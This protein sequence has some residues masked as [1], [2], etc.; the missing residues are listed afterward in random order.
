M[1]NIKSS[2]V[3][4]INQELCLFG[5]MRY[6]LD[7]VYQKYSGNSIFLKCSQTVA[8]FLGNK[9]Q[10]NQN[11]SCITITENEENQNKYD[12]RAGPQGHTF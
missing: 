3:A 7:H 9:A 8:F 4:G 1:R 12:L 2:S 10:K 6:H 5:N 11:Y